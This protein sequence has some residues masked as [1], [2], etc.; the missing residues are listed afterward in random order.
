M[1]VFI[2]CGHF[3]A[4]AEVHEIASLYEVYDYIPCDAATMIFSDIDNTLLQPDTWYGSDAWFLQ[5]LAEEKA[6]GNDSSEALD[7]IVQEYNRFHKEEMVPQLVE[8]EA[9]VL[10]SQLRTS[11]IPVY[12]VTA[13]NVE[14]VDATYNQ[15]KSLRL[16]LTTT[17]SAWLLYDDNVY[18]AYGVV[19]SGYVRKSDALLAFLDAILDTRPEHIIFI[20]DKHHNVADIDAA[21]KQRGI[22][23]DALRYSYCD[24]H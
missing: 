3:F 9:D 22:K 7:R 14:L 2:V 6:V 8:H 15:L 16:A 18:V 1:L 4:I 17:P 11:G 13:R 20:D 24:A 21:C 10:I 12:A 5:K 23:V 19:F